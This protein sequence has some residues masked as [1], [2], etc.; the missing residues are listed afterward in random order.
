[1]NFYKT[2][3]V[4]ELGLATPT[5]PL[6]RTVSIRS[7]LDDAAYRRIRLNFFRMHRQFVSGNTRRAR[8]DYFMLVCGPL[9]AEAQLRSP[10]GAASAF[11]N[12]GTFK[13]DF[14]ICARLAAE[15]RNARLP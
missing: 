10:D 14:F 6:V 5:H 15:E 9:S 13:K 2:D 11:A 8:Y 3:P 7:M 12:D 1:M 4:R